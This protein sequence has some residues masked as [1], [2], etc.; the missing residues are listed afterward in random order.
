M[1]GK[2]TPKPERG[3]QSW[4]GPFRTKM[5]P[6]RKIVVEETPDEIDGDQDVI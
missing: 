3:R 5:K 6:S 2:K 1:G 4:S